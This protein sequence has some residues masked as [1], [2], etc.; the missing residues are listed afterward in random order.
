M[1]FAFAWVQIQQSRPHEVNCVVLNASGGQDV[2]P[3]AA[4]FAEGFVDE[5]LH[6]ARVFGQP[7]GREW[8]S[9]GK[10][11]MLALQ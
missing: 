5:G 9:T 11:V 10:P 6:F 2:S 3:S 8:L 1:Q 7:V 4:D